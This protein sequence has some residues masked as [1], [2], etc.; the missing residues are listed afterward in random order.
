MVIEGDLIDAKF[1]T[2]HLRKGDLLT[3]SQLKAF[4]K[5]PVTAEIDGEKIDIS[6]GQWNDRHERELEDLPKELEDAASL[7]ADFR[8]EYQEVEKEIMALSDAK[9]YKAKKK[10]LEKQL[11]RKYQGAEESYIKTMSLRTK[12]LELQALQI[13]LFSP[14]L[15][16][17]A[18][19]EKVKFYAPKCI[20]IKKEDGSEDFL[21]KSKEDINSAPFAATR[22]ISL[23]SLFIRGVDVSFF[24]DAPEE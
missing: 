10:E 14:C 5:R 8:N 23:F 18:N 6:E 11:E 2:T 22:V 19:F 7:F 1:K 12:V 16:E 21:F 3:R 17:R 4:Y 20:K 13:E 9:K 15:E 24:G